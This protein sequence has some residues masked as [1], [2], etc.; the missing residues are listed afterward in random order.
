MK[1]QFIYPDIIEEILSACSKH[2][3]DSMAIDRF[4]QVIQNG[5]INITSV[6]EKDIRDFLIDIEGKIELVKFT[7][8][9]CDQLYAS[10]RIA[11]EVISWF[12]Q[13]KKYF[14]E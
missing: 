6:E 14:Q 13:R 5:E 9:Y 3:S 4:Q 10:K 12:N 1:K 11:Y 2:L 7:L 8:D